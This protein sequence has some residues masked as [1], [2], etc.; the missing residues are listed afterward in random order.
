MG[1]SVSY[2][3]QHTVIES[4]TVT[5]HVSSHQG[6]NFKFGQSTTEINEHQVSSY[7]DKGSAIKMPDN[8]LVIL[9]E[10]AQKLGRDG[11]PSD[12]NFAR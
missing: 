3:Y 10:A 12:N 9:S 5:P 7:H 2:Q 4:P 1:A 6:N 11:W 8:G